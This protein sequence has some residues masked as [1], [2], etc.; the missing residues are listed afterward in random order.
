MVIF[1]CKMYLCVDNVSMKQHCLQL[2]SVCDNHYKTPTTSMLFIK[3]ILGGKLNPMNV[4]VRLHKH[5]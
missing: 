5:C 3:Y 4:Q 2:G 1:L